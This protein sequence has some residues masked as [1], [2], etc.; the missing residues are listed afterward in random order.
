[1]TTKPGGGGAAYG[2]CCCYPG[3]WEYRDCW[4]DPAELCLP[5]SPCRSKLGP[6]WR[7]KSPAQ[8]N[9]WPNLTWWIAAIT[10]GYD[11]YCYLFEDGNSGAFLLC[12]DAVPKGPDND[13][14]TGPYSH[15]MAASVTIGA[16]DGMQVGDS[17]ALIMEYTTTLTGKENY[18]EIR[19]TQTDA[20]NALIEIFQVVEDVST[21]LDECAF[22]NTIHENVWGFT[23]NGCISN[24]RLYGTVSG[25]SSMT[26]SLPAPAPPPE[27]PVEPG[28]RAGFKHYIDR[29]AMVAPWLLTQV[30]D[31][32]SRCP[33][34]GICACVNAS[35]S[36]SSGGDDVDE[37]EPI[38][39][40][41]TA[42]F[43]A[44]DDCSA[45]DGVTVDL[46]IGSCEHY[47]EA[48]TG[49]IT[50]GCL[51]PFGE[52]LDYREWSMNLQCPPAGAG[53]SISEFALRINTSDYP[54]GCTGPGS[55]NMPMLLYP[56]DESTCDPFVLVFEAT[57]TIDNSGA[58]TQTTSGCKDECFPCGGDEESGESP[59]VCSVV[60]PDSIKTVYYKII[61]TE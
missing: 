20:A 27:N 36:S 18:I 55:G 41:L 35:G 52:L 37:K 45:L 13:E 48:W 47:E 61:I 1:M 21:K 15:F 39:G 34:C 10:Q 46:S 59:Y 12:R 58:P 17:Y 31:D 7:I 56:T 11:E 2:W 6:H 5:N 22:A 4:T 42:T 49:H 33:S 16:Y 54:C 51:A 24:G 44:E 30:I 28:W 43:I 26:I 29:L 32:D 57:Y 40:Q 60:F 23:I 53:N 14:D 19:A 3:C 8:L 9:P 50:D 25:L 38:S